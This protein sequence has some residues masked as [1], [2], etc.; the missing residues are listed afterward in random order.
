MVDRI[1]KYETLAEDLQEVG[2]QMGFE[3]IL[4]TK[5]KTGFREDIALSDAQKDTIYKAFKAS[6]R[7]TGYKR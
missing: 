7:H 1:L 6:N 4:K 2:R 3:F 5:A